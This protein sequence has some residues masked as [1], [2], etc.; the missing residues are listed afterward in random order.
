MFV[1]TDRHVC[2]VAIVDTLFWADLIKP[3]VIN[4]LQALTEFIEI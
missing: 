2:A 3:T 1:H 4:S